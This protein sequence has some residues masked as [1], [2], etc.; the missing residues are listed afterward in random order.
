[1][2]SQFETAAAAIVAPKLLSKFK[3]RYLIYGA[4]AYYGLKY[5]ASRGVFPQQTGA[6]VDLIDKGIDLAKHQVGIGSNLADSVSSSM[7]RH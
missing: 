6:A 7:S 5:L 3:F 1:M 2:N 4:A